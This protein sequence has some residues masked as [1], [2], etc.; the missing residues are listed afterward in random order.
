[1]LWF[2]S[3]NISLCALF[4]TILL[5][6]S[7]TVLTRP[8]AVAIALLMVLSPLAIVPVAADNPEGDDLEV[9]LRSLWL[10]QEAVTVQD[11]NYS[12]ALECEVELAFTA[13]EL[14]VATSGL[15]RACT[16]STPSDVRP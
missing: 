13:D 8:I 10:C 5:R 3:F 4:G 9:L 16:F 6:P 14:V 15:P 11:L 1:M 12:K 7:F 2:T